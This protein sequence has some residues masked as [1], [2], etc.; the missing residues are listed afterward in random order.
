[1]Q[2]DAAGLLGPEALHP[3]ADWADAVVPAQAGIYTIWT[4]ADRAFIYVGIAG[5]G[6]ERPGRPRGLKRRLG[7]HAKGDRSGD[8]FCIY[9]Q[10]RFVL[11]L[12]TPADVAAIAARRLSLDALV[13]AHVRQNLGF[14]AVPMDLAQARAV[15][16]QLKRGA[17]QFGAPLLNPGSLPD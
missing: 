15:E 16:L 9:V 8:R 6:S 17:W 7:Q 2:V 13:R 3:F 5:D 14:R 11:P 1:M 4:L 10:D 12:L